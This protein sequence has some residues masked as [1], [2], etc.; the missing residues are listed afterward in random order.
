MTSW[1][2][3]LLGVILTQALVLNLKF[4]HRAKGY[5]LRAATW[6]WSTLFLVIFFET[7][8]AV[9]LLKL[10]ASKFSFV[11]LPP[12]A[13]LVGVLVVL[14]PIGLEEILFWKITEK[15]IKSW[16]GRFFRKLN[17]AAVRAFGGG[18][19]TRMEQDV[20]DWQTQSERYFGLGPDAFR[21][22]I[23]QVYYC[24]MEDVAALRRDASF[25]FRD[26]GFS[27][28]GHLY[29]LAGHLGR[30]RLLDELKNECHIDFTG[31]ER[32]RVR[33]TSSDRLEPGKELRFYD[34]P[35]IVESI[36]NKHKVKGSGA[37]QKNLIGSRVTKH[38]NKAKKNSTAKKDKS[39]KVVK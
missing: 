2:L 33:G 12:V 32:R 21:R 8:V 23:R 13:F 25:L 30:K 26:A 10:A 34:V 5:L 1:L 9:A 11:E 19:R 28:Y 6:V 7:V 14:L 22:R 16:W 36:L 18:I 37:K 3:L 20:F 24:H 27:P 4:Y 39:N 29:I 35:E 15:K 31:H 38:N 17:L